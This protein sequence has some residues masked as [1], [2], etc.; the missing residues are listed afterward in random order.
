MKDLMTLEEAARRLGI[1]VTTLR[2]WVRNGLVPAYRLGQRFARV[3][4][5]EVL[6]ALSEEG[7][8][9]EAGSAKGDR[10]AAP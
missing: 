4:W 9:A 6:G 3:S 5:D 10:Y 2:G 7:Q 8:E 1:H